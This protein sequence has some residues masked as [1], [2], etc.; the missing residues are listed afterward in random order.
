[1]KVK[2]VL[3]AINDELLEEFLTKE[4]SNIKVIA[5]IQYQEALFGYLEKNPDADIDVILLKE[6]L[7]GASLPLQVVSELRGNYPNIRVVYFITTSDTNKLNTIKTALHFNCVYD[8]I[9][10]FNDYDAETVYEAIFKPKTFED[11]KKENQANSFEEKLESIQKFNELSENN[12][13]LDKKE[14]PIV[15]NKGLNYNNNVKYEYPPSKVISFW[16]PK[17]GAGA[18]TLALNTAYMIAKY[19]DIDI[20]IADF[21]KI[22]N[23]HLLLNADIINEKN[24]EYAYVQQANGKLNPYT[25]E[26]YIINGKSLNCGY[27]NLY[28]MPGAVHKINFF[29]RLVGKD[30]PEEIAKIFSGIINNLREKYTIVILVLSSDITHIPTAVALKQCNQINIVLENDV[31]SIYNLNRYWDKDSGLFNR[32]KISRDKCKF[33]LN[34]NYVQD[35]FYLTKFAKLTGRDIDVFIP[36]IPDEIFNS[37]KRANPT[38]L[39]HTNKKTRDAFADIVNTI[40]LMEF[41]DE[42]DGPNTD[43]NSGNKKGFLQKFLKKSKK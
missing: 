34:K 13:D 2:N 3:C 43:N 29:E 4:V 9:Y 19:T 15:I 6:N 36:L 23:L 38:S 39:I 41:T 35:N 24:I 1:M 26:N 22:P 17:A 40:T 25:I 21:S 10:D 30:S 11:I 14:S 20:C 28:V 12:F 32:Y 31:C 37:V 33:I 42:D 8:I 16:S 27:A 5:N 18:K 7:P